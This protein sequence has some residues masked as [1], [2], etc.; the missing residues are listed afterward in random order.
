M[1]SNWIIPFVAGLFVG[2]EFQDAP[3]V[4]PYIEA[5]IRKLIQ[6]SKEIFEN[7]K[8]A[9]ESKDHTREPRRSSSWWGG[10]ETRE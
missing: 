9:K 5:G 7:A 10:K 4:R 8:D 3:K 6:V 2:Q 1:C